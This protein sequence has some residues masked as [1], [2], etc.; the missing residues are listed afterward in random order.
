MGNLLKSANGYLRERS[1]DDLNMGG[2][3]R[4]AE[5]RGVF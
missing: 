3:E 4:F 1:K 5:S 2:E